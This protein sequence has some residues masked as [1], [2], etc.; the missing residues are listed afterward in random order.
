MFDAVAYQ[1]NRTGAALAHLVSEIRHALPEGR[2]LPND[3]WQRR[4]AFI[5]ALLWL[6]AI[7]IAC[8]GLIVGV[9]PLHSLAEGGVV[10]ATAIVASWG[11]RSRRFRATAASFGLLTASAILVHLSGGLIEMHF[12]YFVMIVVIILYQD[13]APFLLAITYVALQH[14]IVGVLMPEAVYNHPDAWANPWK[15]AVIHAAFVMGASIAGIVSWRL[16]EAARAHAEQLL[17][18]A[19]EGICGLDIDGHITFVNPI[20]A[21]MLGYGVEELL[22][23]PLNDVLRS[24]EAA[25]AEVA[26][27]AESPYAVLEDGGVHRASGQIWRRKDG[28]T[29]PV[30]Y[31]STPIRDVRG[32]VGAIITFRDITERKRREDEI[33]TLNAELEH[34]VEE[35]TAELAAT[36]KELEA[37]AYS[38]SH[39]LRAPLRS[40]NGFSQVLLEDHAPQLTEDARATLHRVRAASQRMGQ[41][42]DDLLQLSGVTRTEMRRKTVDL[43]AVVQ[44]VAADLQ[45]TEPGRHVEFVI[46]P[47]ITAKGDPRLLRLVL[48]NLLG[49]AWKFTSRHP[50]A[51]IEF[52]A[53]PAEGK[54]VY[55]VRDDGAGFDMAYADKL[56]GTFQRLHSPA[57]FDGTGIGLA[58]VQRIIHRHGG[59]IWAEGAQ[60]R[61]ATFSFTL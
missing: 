25:G 8:Y 4:H 21:R 58:T 57:E 39:D 7:G 18:S 12:H 23:R 17:Q 44:S 48:E 24:S 45:Q 3:V 31:V 54:P 15:W 35:R 61:G 53:V 60:E 6:H 11:N 5:L 43:S 20:A 52:G 37:F 16:N 51:R 38:V 34:R 59:R 10:A 36:N 30:E 55:Y 13:W 47:G 28:S 46:E 1:R 19:G 14:G 26:G 32:L 40:I 2:A 56:F 29:F 41:L 33:R 42:I 50:Q 9:G 22:G 27:D 49:N